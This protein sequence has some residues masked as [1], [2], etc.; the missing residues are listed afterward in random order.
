M[1]QQKKGVV[2]NT[3]DVRLTGHTE[4]APF[5]LSAS[6]VTPS[7]ASGG[8]D[9]TVLLWNLE[10]YGGGSL[11]HGGGGGNGSAAGGDALGARTTLRG[12]TKTITSVAFKPESDSMLMSTSDDHVIKLWDIRQSDAVQSVRL[13]SLP[14]GPCR[15]A[16]GRTHALIPARTSSRWAVR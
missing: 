3:P 7:V 13:R 15:A 12:H 16:L 9:K 5:A 2:R 8:E 14:P 1:L 6:S 11:L 10:D 4:A